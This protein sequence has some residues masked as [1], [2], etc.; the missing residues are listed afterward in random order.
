MTQKCL[1]FSG[2]GVD[3]IPYIKVC[4]DQPISDCL[5]W[6]VLVDLLGEQFIKLIFRD[7]PEMGTG[8]RAGLGD[9]ILELPIK[10]H[11][12]SRLRPPISALKSHSFLSRLC[13][14][15]KIH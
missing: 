15:E 4:V 11:C 12:A 13:W 3:T 10:F 14:F 1:L 8:D 7:V 2:L 5:S 6:R 9:L